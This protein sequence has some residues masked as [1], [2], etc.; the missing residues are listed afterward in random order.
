M[1]T[2][3]V[4]VPATPVTV[5]VDM[6]TFHAPPDTRALAAQPGFRFVPDRARNGS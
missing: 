6:S 2:V 5:Q 3:S 4:H 1:T